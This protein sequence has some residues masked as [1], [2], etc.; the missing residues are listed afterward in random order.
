M[1]CSNARA[2]ASRASASRAR[3]VQ[4]GKLELAG[5]SRVEVETHADAAGVGPLQIHRIAPV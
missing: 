5:G 2:S 3:L 1:S 4:D